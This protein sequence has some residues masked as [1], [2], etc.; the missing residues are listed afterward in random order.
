MP[1]KRLEAA[2][3]RCQATNQSGAPCAAPPTRDSHYCS[4]HLVPGRAAELGKRGGQQNRTAPDLESSEPIV[5]PETANDV[6]RLLAEG[7]A[8]TMAGRMS[9]RVGT[10]VSYIGTALLKVIE[11][12]DLDRRLRD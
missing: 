5:I 9:P 12:T 6:R 11:A 3:S 10:A 2:N 8:L 4:L 1:V 7:L